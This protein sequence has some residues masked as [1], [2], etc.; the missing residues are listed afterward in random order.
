MLSKLLDLAGI[1]P[2]LLVGL[3]AVS[4]SGWA[5]AGIN[6]LMLVSERTRVIV[7]KGE[8]DNAAR[9]RDRLAAEL[10]ARRDRDAV[11]RDW[12]SDP[13]PVGRLRRQ[14]ERRSGG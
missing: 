10:N 3:A 13:D 9:E 6:R 1:K 8:R 11:E 7:A 4:L 2:W 12:D 14:S 5:A